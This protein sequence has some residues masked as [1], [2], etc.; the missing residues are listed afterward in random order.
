MSRSS[1]HLPLAQLKL[2]HRTVRTPT[3][4]ALPIEVRHRVI[5]LLARLLR[6]AAVRDQAVDAVGGP[7]DE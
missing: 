7:S 4:N 3:W 1:K 6:E 5:P 2:F